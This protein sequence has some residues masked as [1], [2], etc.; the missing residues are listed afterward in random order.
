MNEIF[1]DEILSA[2]A[3]RI[4]R[5]EARNA[6]AY[7]AAFPEERAELGAL[8]DLAENVKRVLVPV[9]PSDAFRNRL[10]AGLQLAGHHQVTQQASQSPVALRNLNYWWVGAAAIGASV[11]AGSIIAWVVRS[12]AN[13]SHATLS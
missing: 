3:D 8:M 7:L 1:W 2:H 6:D 10:R 9:H 5:G 13:Q 12:R 4:L 11:A